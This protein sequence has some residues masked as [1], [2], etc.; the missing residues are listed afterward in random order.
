MR[1][2]GSSLGCTDNH[3][4]TLPS[5][6]C[7]RRHCASSDV[8]P[9]PAGACTRI[10]G[11]PRRRSWSDLRRGLAT[12]WRG[13]RGGVTLSRR[14]SETPARRE[15]GGVATAFNDTLPNDP[16][17]TSG[18]PA[19]SALPDDIL[20]AGRRRD[21]RASPPAPGGLDRAAAA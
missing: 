11:W 13:T 19:P 17:P 3:A 8:L 2:D 16:L 9:Y 4:T 5:A 18:R 6:R 10:T 20:A 7:S 1:R 14:S 15:G 21:G 12:W